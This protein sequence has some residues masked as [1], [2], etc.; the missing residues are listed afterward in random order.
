MAPHNFGSE[1]LIRQRGEQWKPLT[2]AF[3][4]EAKW[5]EWQLTSDVTRFS[6]RL[7]EI[8][9][10]Y[11]HSD[12]IYSGEIQ[13]PFRAGEVTFNVNEEQINSYVYTDSRKM[14]ESQ[15]LAMLQDILQEAEVCFEI[16]GLK[17]SFDSEAFSRDLSWPQWQYICEQFTT[18][19]RLIHKLEKQPHRLL[20]QTTERVSRDKLRNLTP[21]TEQWAE[22]QPQ[23]EGWQNPPKHLHTVKLAETVDTLDN[24][25]IKHRLRQLHDLLER[26]QETG[27][28]PKLAVRYIQRVKRWLNRTFFKHVADRV[29]TQMITQLLR[30][31]PTYRSVNSWFENL[32]LFGNLKIGFETLI[33]LKQTFE[34]YEMWCFMNIVKQLRERQLV[35]D[36][37][38]LFKQK[39]NQLFLDLSSN[40]ESRIQMKSGQA[41]YFQRNY[42]ANSKEYFTITH[43]MIPDIVIEDDSTIWV[44]DPKYRVAGNLPM[45]IGEMHKYKDGIFSRSTRNRS[46]E[47]AFIITPVAANKEQL[48]DRELQEEYGIGA[49]VMVVGQEVKLPEWLVEKVIVERV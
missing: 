28:S 33:P 27:P 35:I 38:N 5:Y 1:L 10:A 24:R 14:I 6:F 2:D 15:Y 49:F 32:Y 37:S 39:K 30:K 8:P 11:I 36:T 7:N 9:L 3:L 18:L 45:A 29:P 12:Q 46:V 13:M 34:L 47:G 21:R 25:I 43:A 19:E 20:N 26:Y 40:H 31:H 41:L 48:H 42:R 16:S 23:F 4:E 44:F 22:S 17:S